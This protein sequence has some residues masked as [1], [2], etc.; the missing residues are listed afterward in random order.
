MTY[1]NEICPLSIVNVFSRFFK[2]VYSLPDASGGNLHFLN[3]INNVIQIN[4]EPITE[5]EI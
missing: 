3:D 1:E 2:S 5:N 4:Y